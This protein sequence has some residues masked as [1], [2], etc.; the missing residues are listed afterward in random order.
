MV[1]KQNDVGA[2]IRF[3]E[4]VEGDV[5]GDA[6][7]T[8]GPGEELDQNRV[9]ALRLSAREFLDGDVLGRFLVLGVGLGFQSLDP[10]VE[11]FDFLGL[12][13]LLG[14][15][16]QGL[17][18][19]QTLAGRGLGVEPG[20]QLFAE[21]AG[22]FAIIRGQGLEQTDARLELPAWAVMVGI[23]HGDFDPFLNVLGWHLVGLGFLQQVQHDGRDAQIAGILATISRS[24]SKAFLAVVIR[25]KPKTRLLH[26]G[27]ANR[28]SFWPPGPAACLRS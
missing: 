14:D 6:R 17:E 16:L 8:L 20:L 23:A 3:C 10:G 4:S 22:E 1:L 25:D 18:Q 15:V 9:R 12:A 13:V 11:L 2:G 5:G 26:C 19:P 27:P 24:S 7:G 21:G 28:S